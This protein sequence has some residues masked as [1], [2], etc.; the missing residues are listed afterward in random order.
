MIGN[1]AYALG[2]GRGI[3]GG[4]KILA[5]RGEVKE[6]SNMYNH[7]RHLALERLE[8]EAAE[9]GLQR[10]GRHHHP[11]HPVRARRPRDAHGRHRLV[12]PGARAAQDARTP[13]S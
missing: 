4:L 9:R 13:R 8:A 11:D 5:R 10:G 1:V 6:F 7:T 3:T 12:Q 2:I